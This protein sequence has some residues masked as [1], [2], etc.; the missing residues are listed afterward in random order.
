MSIRIPHQALSFGTHTA[1]LASRYG[2]KA[3]L[4]KAAAHANPAMLVLEAAVSVMDAANAWLELKAA[5]VHRDGLRTTIPKEK[6]ALEIDRLKLKEEIVLAR[7]DLSQEL[8]LRERIGK[9]NLLCARVCQEILGDMLA[10][11]N[12]EIPSIDHFERLNNELEVAWTKM[13]EALD[14]YNRTTE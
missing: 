13:R 1:K 6:A 5:R 3:G 9:I 14:Y 2:L 10:I 7:E 12:E 4:T 11:R 8:A